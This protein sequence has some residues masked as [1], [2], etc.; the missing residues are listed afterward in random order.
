MQSAS[1]KPAEAPV[2]QTTSRQLHAQG[3]QW[4]RKKVPSMPCLRSIPERSLALS[5]QDS[6][7]GARAS[8]TA[9]SLPWRAPTSKPIRDLPDLSRKH[10]GHQR[11]YGLGEFT[12][13][14]EHGA[15][16]GTHPP[17]PELG[18]TCALTGLDALQTPS[19]STR[20]FALTPLAVS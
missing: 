14:C 3:S 8:I 5:F 18:T 7:Q 9:M 20:A 6:S 4:N 1:P 15:C 16:S 10:G 12:Q 13:S 19:V 2:T 11:W 17:H